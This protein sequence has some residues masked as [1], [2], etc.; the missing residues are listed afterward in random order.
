M[1]KATRA[2]SAC[3]LVKFLNSL[4]NGLNQSNRQGSQTQQGAE[5]IAVSL[6][7]TRLPR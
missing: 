7:V 4:S 2:G 5:R 6:K 3:L 1:K